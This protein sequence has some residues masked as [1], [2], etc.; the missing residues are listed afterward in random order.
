MG[1]AEAIRRVE[2]DADIR[3]VAALGRQIWTEHY[4]DILAPG[5]VP[6][7][8][9]RFHSEAIIRREIADEGYEYH[10][11]SNGTAD[12]GYIG[13]QMRDETLYLSK[14]YILSSARGS[15]LGRV[16]LDYLRGR[17][18]AAGCRAITLGVNKGNTGTIA[19]YERIGFRIIGE[20]VNDIGGGF[21][22]D[23]Y[24]MEWAL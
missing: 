9:E 5:Q 14:I 4:T 19:A 7:M 6:Y 17:A 1:Q 2:L 21:V 16:A 8:L 3:A 11:L 20:M 13:F 23:D 15:G 24:A 12:V 22:M 18:E 10:L